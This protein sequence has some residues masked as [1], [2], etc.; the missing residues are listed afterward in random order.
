VC[1]D[2][3]SVLEVIVLEEALLG[4]VVVPEEV[5]VVGQDDPETGVS[6]P[7]VVWAVAVVSVRP[8]MLPFP[9]EA[10]EELVMWYRSA[11]DAC[12]GTCG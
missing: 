1:L 4:S 3:C 7:W 6:T 2:R 12:R 5:E 8:E 11:V 9:P 10:D